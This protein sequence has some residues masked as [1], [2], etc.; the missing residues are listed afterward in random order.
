V[1]YL[2]L[3]E[4]PSGR[5]CRPLFI[6]DDP[7]W[8][9]LFGGALTELTLAYNYQQFG[10]LTPQEMA[11]ACALVIEAWYEEICGACELPDG[12]PVMRIG[13]DYHYEQLIDGSWQAPTGD[14][15]IPAVPAR[16]EPTSEERRCL[17]AANA[18]YVLKTLYEEITDSAGGGLAAIEALEL[19]VIIIATI[20]APYIA[21]AYRAL[22]AVAFG[23]WSIGFDLA[24]NI[25]ADYWNEDF[26][27]FL[28]CALYKASTDTDG[29]VTFD[30]EAL[31]RE[32]VENINIIDPTL[33]TLA[34]AGQVRWML[35]QFGADA[36]NFS[37]VQTNI[38]EHDCSECNCVDEPFDI[39]LDFTESSYDFGDIQGTWVDGVGFPNN[40]FAVTWGSSHS[41]TIVLDCP[42]TIE[43]FEIYFDGVQAQTRIVAVIK[44]GTTVYQTV[45]SSNTPG[46]SPFSTEGEAN[47][48][49]TDALGLY[50]LM[51]DPTMDHFT[52]TGARVWGHGDPP[53][54][55]TP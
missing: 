22:A 45:D 8:L 3:D 40:Q 30:L 12:D 35:T 2:T 33:S 29:V 26:S 5:V 53:N 42:C 43:G 20:V 44:N 37:G 24:E 47:Y 34:I 39:M 4:I 55:I 15:A 19:A 23:V 1:P 10:T 14:Y 38:D 17:A 6:P 48:V 50:F 32:L 18:E 31:N 11:D 46:T 7:L 13:E 21:L 28:I 9:A 54:F 16:E 25:T 51:H 41:C 49:A 27:N 52:V 36:L